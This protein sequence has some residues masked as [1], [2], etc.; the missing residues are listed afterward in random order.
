MPAPG[1]RDFAPAYHCQAVVDSEGQ[2]IVAAPATNQASD[3]QQA[4]GLVEETIG[5]TGVIPKEVSAD[6]RYYS[7]RVVDELYARGTDPYVAPDK[8]RHGRVLPPAPGVASPISCRPGI[9]C[10]GSC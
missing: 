8:T 3:Q 9:G 4:T 5:N 10:G 7:A 1:G 6:A 2:V